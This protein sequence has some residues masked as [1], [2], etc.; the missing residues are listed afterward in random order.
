[1]LVLSGVGLGFA[2][3]NVSFGAFLTAY[4]VLVMA[5]SL[6]FKRRFLIDVIVLA[7]LYTLR[8]V[9]GG[10]ATG[11]EVSSW[12]LAFSVFFFLSLAFV[13]RL[14]C[15]Q[16]FSSSHWQ[17]AFR[18]RQSD[19]HQK[20]LAVKLPLPRLKQPRQPNFIKDR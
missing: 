13:K 9:A 3:V 1:M 16:S 20:G 6:Q 8:L 18:K 19:L 14:V 17:R 15:S 4:V 12:L 5:Y 2:A 11:V 10:A 7:G